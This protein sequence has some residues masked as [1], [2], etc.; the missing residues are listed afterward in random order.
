M[1]VLV[2]AWTIAPLVGVDHGAPACASAERAAGV[3]TS[4]E[5]GGWTHGEYLAEWPGGMCWIP[6]GGGLELTVF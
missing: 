6:P 5:R 3:E 2:A 4:P 1:A